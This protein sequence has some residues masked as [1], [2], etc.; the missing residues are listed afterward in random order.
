MSKIIQDSS[1]GNQKEIVKK[2]GINNHPKIQR[3]IIFR[4]NDQIIKT[5]KNK[6]ILISEG[7]STFIG[8]GGPNNLI[9][10][11]RSPSPQY[12]KIMTLPDNNNY[13]VFETKEYNENLITNEKNDNDDNHI[14]YNNIDYNNNN[15]Y[16]SKSQYKYQQQKN[17][18]KRGQVEYD[19]CSYDIKRIKK[20][21]RYD[22]NSPERNSKV[23]VKTILCS[24]ISVT[25]TQVDK[26]II[27]KAYN[28]YKE[29]YEETEIMIKN[30]MKKI[31]E[32]NNENV[33]E[34]GFSI[35]SEDNNRNNYIIEEYEEKIQE[36]SKTIYSLQN[37]KNTLEQQI[38]KMKYIRNNKDF[39]DLTMQKFSFNFINDNIY[40]K[41]INK[42]LKRQNIKFINITG[43]KNIN[44]E[45]KHFKIQEIENLTI[46]RS[47]K[48]INNIIDYS[49]SI[50]IIP[51]IKK[52][53]EKPK[54]SLDYVNEIF[55]PGKTQFINVIERLEGFNILRKEKPK[56]IIN[57][58]ESNL[59]DKV[60]LRKNQNY[61][62]IIEKTNNVFIPKKEKELFTWDTFY[63]Q[64]LYILPAKKKIIHEI[65]YLDGLEI[66]KEHIPKYNNIIEATNDIFIPN[67]KKELFTW[68]TFYGQELYILSKKKKKVLEIEYLDDIEILKPEKPAKEIELNDNIDLLP[69]P[70]APFE[71]NFIDKFCI[72][73]NNKILKA[74]PNQQNIIEYKDEIKLLGKNIGKN[75]IQKVSLVE[76]YSCSKP[77]II[78]YEEND[79]LFIPGVTK[80]ENIIQ[81]L[82]NIEFIHEKV[83]TIE[84][85]NEPI[86]I[87]NILA[88][89]KPENEKQR[90]E[91]FDIF[92]KPRPENVVDP[93]NFIFIESLSKN[94]L[95]E[96]EFGEEIKI[97]K[98]NRP[99][100]LMEELEGI[101]ILK[102]EKQKP[103]NIIQ[104]N[105]E[106][107]I[108]PQ[109]MKTL[110]L[111][112]ENRD[113]F[114][115]NSIQKQKQKNR[116]QRVSELKILKNNKKYIKI[117]QR[118]ESFYIL[119][120]KRPKNY[121]QI[122]NNIN[123]LGIE[124]TETNKFEI[125]FPDEMIIAPLEKPINQI[126]KTEEI[127]IIKKQKM[128][129]IKIKTSELQILKK[130]K[131]KNKIQK[132]DNFNIYTKTKAK[133][134]NKNKEL[135]IFFGEEIFI[136]NLLKPKN[137]PQ[138]L[139][140]FNILK[141]QKQKA[142]NKVEVIDEIEILSEPK[143]VNNYLEYEQN[144]L[145]TIEH[146]EKPENKIER[147][148]EFELL[149]EELKNEN[150]LKNKKNKN[151][152][153]NEINFQIISECIREIYLQ[154][155]QG[156]AIF[157]KEK[158]PNEID[159]NYNFIIKREYDSVLTRPIWDDLYIQKEEFNILPIHNNTIKLRNENQDDFLIEANSQ[160]SKYN[161]NII[162]NDS[163]S[164]SRD[165]SEDLCRTCG[166]IK[167]I[168][169][170]NNSKINII[171]S[172]NESIN[173]KNTNV[174]N[175]NVIN[176]KLYKTLLALPKNEI[177][178]I[179]NIEISQEDI[180]NKIILSDDEFTRGK[181]KI[182]H[183]NKY[184]IK[185]NKIKLVKRMECNKISNMSNSDICNYNQKSNEENL[186]VNENQNF[187]INNRYNTKNMLKKSNYK[188]N[189]KTNDYNNNKFY[190]S[191][192]SQYT[193]Y[194]NCS[195]SGNSDINKYQSKSQLKTIVINKKPKRKLFRFEE[196]KGIKII[197]QQ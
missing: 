47:K 7:P 4:K 34:C 110:I 44:K 142:K 87:I 31:W 93:N 122:T 2:N 71:I 163:F 90:I 157:K 185:R 131:P 166:G 134:E 167:R 23:L 14:I 76:I 78:E 135:E 194:R 69:E 133:K 101:T 95:L 140:G 102:K 17:E 57:E 168:N 161:K 129:N 107:E 189:N 109:K 125:V 59:N 113:L 106:I 18:S 49:S 1:G 162:I 182:N 178:Y 48:H 97:E 25:Y 96:I 149:K 3:K 158:E 51:K 12:S 155:L 151:S 54:I 33:T 143:K 5:T 52:I 153:Q 116:L 103:L 165:L 36:L 46:L 67:K 132:R 75:I 82:D 26:P 179:D 175:L 66:I 10:G 187:R 112:S 60:I 64:E 16:I 111:E 174:N 63:G 192:Y 171:N 24:P 181:N 115:I 195:N 126:Q 56:I 190:Q 141:K 13:Q 98:M 50:S 55:L 139:E 148:D 62:N 94:E 137:I 169:E 65:E 152:I 123:I 173:C 41:W 124:K 19:S 15:F 85:I 91:S 6:K 147:I 39:Y 144:E 159:K 73:E 180:N 154:R 84:Y 117:L 88:L 80:P 83:N 42:N 20:R 146:T 176:T 193:F 128:K 191:G 170:Y 22:Y 58:N 108:L 9:S 92:R 184:N 99:E 177:D 29:E 145:F 38:E 11:E 89:E 164:N 72:S 35:F 183:N 68:D 70:K 32:N 61:N 81:I 100:N 104:Y 86:D 172:K 138:R 119:G 43:V 37:T 28:E 40:R 120:K 21:I 27:K 160:Y 74:P 121:I 156:F 105:D 188:Y 30:K 114:T 130:V 79:Y 118:K 136:E 186:E 53:I 45:H 77:K 197:Y 150:V 127:T 8:K 196:G